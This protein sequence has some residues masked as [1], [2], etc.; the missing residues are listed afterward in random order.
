MKIAMIGS[1]AAGSVF[2]SYLK[3]GGAELWLVD[4][5]KAHMDKIAAD[6]MTF[7]SPDGEKLLTGFHTAPSA[8]NIGIMDVVILMVKAT[9][10]DDIMP[11][12]KNCIGEST[13]VVSLQNGLGNEEVLGRYVPGSRILYG[14]GTIGTELPE[15]GKC[16]SK[17]ESGVI[18]RFGAAEKSPLLDKVGSELEKC[19][20]DGG[21]STC[22]EADIRPFVWKKAIS[23][24]GY[25]TL[26]A[27]LRLKV[28]PILDCESGVELIRKVWAEGC[29]VAMAVTGVDLR[30]DMEEELPRLRDGF[31][32]YYPSMAQDV[33][34][35]Q[36]QT[37]VEL[38]NGAIVRYGKEM[39]IQTPVNEAM[40]LM[41]KT[42]QENYDKQFGK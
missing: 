17:P 37:E 27:L 35:H 38:L 42:I 9:Q 3:L 26:S 14:F 16:V 2:A 12:L 28:G 15:P 41:I 29:A 22:F 40:T 24:S 6:G 20:C 13:V 19:F 7:V 18:M 10:T 4:R 34:M 32:K 23:N 36:R 39:G 11:S 1:G 8:E 31:A 5:Y 30:K 33:L 25:N 21:C